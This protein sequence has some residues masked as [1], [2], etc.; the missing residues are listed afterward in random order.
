MMTTSGYGRDSLISLLGIGHLVSNPSKFPFLGLKDSNY[1]NKKFFN[2]KY[3]FGA[4]AD[5]D[6]MMKI[7][8]FYQ[9]NWDIDAV[10]ERYGSNLIVADTEIVHHV[11]QTNSQVYD[12][13]G[14]ERYDA[15]YV[16]SDINFGS[17]FNLIT[18]LRMEKNKTSYFSFS[19]LDH[20]LPHWIFVGESETHDRENSHFFPA[21]FL[22]FK[23]T[24]WLNIRYAKTRTLTRPDYSN[25]IPLSRASGQYRTIDWRNKFLKPGISENND[26]SISFNQDKLGFITLGYF[27]KDIQDLIYSSGSRIVLPEDTLR[28]DISSNYEYYKI[29]DYSLNNPNKVNLEGWEFDYQTRFFY[30]PSFLNGI[31]FNANY[32]IANSKVQY[33]RTVIEGYFDFELFEYIENNIDGTYTAKLI[34]QPDEIINVSIGYDY[35]GFSSRLSMLYNDDVFMS[36]NFWPELRETTDPYTRWDLSIKQNLPTEGLEIFLNVSNVTEAN[37]VN[38]YNGYNSFGNNLKSEQHYGRTIDLGFRYS[39]NN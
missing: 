29:L 10:Q 19:S 17:K 4:V 27:R 7:Y 2:G 33:P 9:E 3:S 6:L 14:K 23:P 36:T 16:M 22:T 30:L 18:G 1:Q 24:P 37:D 34:D 8:E 39:F 15:S 20:A 32:T 12:Y 5:L 31:V 25:L 26:I 28:Y 35:Q 13:S 21:L 11:H 38:R